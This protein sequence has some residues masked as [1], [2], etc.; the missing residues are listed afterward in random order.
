VLSEN[1]R[2]TD[3][4]LNNALWSGC[5]SQNATSVLV[6]VTGGVGDVPPPP[7]FFLEQLHVATDKET[8]TTRNA[9]LMKGYLQ[10]ERICDVT[11]NSPGKLQPGSKITWLNLI[12]HLVSPWRHHIIQKM[13]G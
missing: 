3:C 11:M 9:S 12:Q 4:F 13:K 2:L 10:R 1:N 5:V 7:L 8:I 6:F